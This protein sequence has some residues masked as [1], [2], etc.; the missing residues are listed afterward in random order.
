MQV[1][2]VMLVCEYL[3]TTVSDFLPAPPV[4]SI[5]SPPS[6]GQTAFP[7]MQWTSGTR[8]NTHNIS[9]VPWVEQETFA[10]VNGSTLYTISLTGGATTEITFTRYLNATAA[11]DISAIQQSTGRCSGQGLLGVTE[12]VYRQFATYKSTTTLTAGQSAYWAPDN[13]GSQPGSTLVGPTVA[14]ILKTTPFVEPYYPQAARAGLRPFVALDDGSCASAC[15]GCQFY[16]PEVSV[17]YW[18]GQNQNTA[19]LTQ[20]EAPD[21]KVKFRALYHRDTNGTSTTLASNVTGPGIAVENGFT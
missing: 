15:G 17:K 1:S 13:F 19:C 5:T 7:F 11:F 12:A 3:R 14:E 10:I 9:V 21:S 20:T 6:S 2:M 18:A 4:S 16:Y 8:I